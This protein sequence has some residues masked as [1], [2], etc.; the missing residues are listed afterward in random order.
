MK[1]GRNIWVG[2]PSVNSGFRRLR[3]RLADREC[4]RPGVVRRWI[5]LQVARAL[6]A[7]PVPIRREE[8]VVIRATEPR[9]RD[10]DRLVAGV[11]ADHRQRRERVL[12]E[13]ADGDGGGRVPVHPRDS[14]TGGAA[15]PT[16][17]PISPS[18]HAVATTEVSTAA[19][20]AS[21]D[22]AMNSRRLGPTTRYAVLR[23][24]ERSGHAPSHIRASRRRRASP[25][26]PC[27]RGRP[28]TRRPGS[29]LFAAARRSGPSRASRARR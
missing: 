20:A 13:P 5:R 26:R 18:P 8:R 21:V 19:I 2:P 4:P 1:G 25:P 9:A 10:A 15:G 24:L 17:P 3:N 28:S 12:S 7:G 16:A 11:R 29:H 23:P 14:S 27:P 6:P 22:C